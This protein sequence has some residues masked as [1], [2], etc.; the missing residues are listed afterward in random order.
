MSRDTGETGGGRSSSLGGQMTALYAAHFVRYL[1]PLITIPYLAR[2]L[3]AETL[4]RLVLIQAYAFFVVQWMEF[5]FGLSATQNVARH[6]ESP[7]RLASI[8]SS[9]FGSQAGLL[10]IAL[11]ATAIIQ[12]LVPML[13]ETPRLLWMGAGAGVLQGMSPFWFL[14]GV[15]RMKEVASLEVASRVLRTAGIFLLVRSPEDLWWVLA[16][17]LAASLLN[18]SV[19]LS[20]VARKV[21]LRWPGVAGI[22]ETLGDS[23][24][25]F[26]VRASASL[27]TAGNVFVLGLYA[28]QLTIAFF[29]GAEKI[30]T[31]L[32]MLFNPAFDALYPRMSFETSNA[33]DRAFELLRRMLLVLGVLSVGMSLGILIFAPLA[34]RLLLGPEFEA[35]VGVLRIFALFP[36]VVVVNLCLGSH[37]LLVRGYR[38]F[39]VST[40]MA[41][42]ILNIALTLLAARW[43]P[44]TAHLGA[45]AAFVLS[46]LV[47]A[48]VLTIMAWRTRPRPG[49]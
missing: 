45:A 34:V 26:I 27:F 20:M 30:A 29:A 36:P 49:A 32:R 10:S 33:P 3:G 28:S 14:R 40:G 22:L 35:S 6:R 24:S 48:V 46:Q 13:G 1:L 8:A 7:G 42:G 39:F 18:A 16:S 2:V 12:Q 43:Q 31:A 37:W 9:V 4:G 44:E 15:E 11:G 38:R 21:P 17:D 25:L 5:G 41:I 19:G 23:W 47:G